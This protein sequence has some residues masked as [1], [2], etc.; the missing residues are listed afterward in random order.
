ME[1]EVDS[2]V[3]LFGMYQDTVQKLMVERADN[4]HKNEASLRSE[5][6]SMDH[7]AHL[8]NVIENLEEVINNLLDKN[9]RLRKGLRGVF[10]AVDEFPRHRL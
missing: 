2:L 7:I 10:K 6:L 9:T 5:K 3:I 8:D 1:K 4:K